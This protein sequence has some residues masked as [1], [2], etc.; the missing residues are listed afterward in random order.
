MEIKVAASILDLS[1]RSPEWNDGVV[2]F[3]RAWRRKIARVVV[4]V[5]RNRSNRL[6]ETQKPHQLLRRLQPIKSCGRARRINQFGL[7]MDG[8]EICQF[9]PVLKVGGKQDGVNT[10]RFRVESQAD[11][12]TGDERW[13]RESPLYR[14]RVVPDV[15]AKHRPRL[16][17][18]PVCPLK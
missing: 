15:M 7:R 1:S 12:S 5:S 3:W 13:Q 6:R 2:E 4:S 9:L 8:K 11:A 17:A 18:Q 16:I 14:A 10:I